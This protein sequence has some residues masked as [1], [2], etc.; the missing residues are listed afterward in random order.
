MDIAMA[1]VVIVLLIVSVSSHFGP[2]VTR[3]DLFFG[4]TV[5]PE[6]RRTDAARRILHGYRTALWLWTVLVIAVAFAF[7]RFV[8]TVALYLAGLFGTLIGAHRAASRH[9][10]VPARVIEVDLAAPPERIPGGPMAALLPFVLLSGLGAWA[11][12][13]WNRL[14][15]RLT[16]HWGMAGP[17]GRVSTSA[18]AVLA[19][20]A[21]P[22]LF[23]LLLT[24]IAFGVLHWSRRIESAGAGAVRERE[25]RRRIVLLI[26]LTEYFLVFPP[27]FALL[28][29][30]WPAVQMWTVAVLLVMA[31]FVATLMR[32][33]QGG[34]GGATA[35]RAPSIG[36]RTPD[37]CWK[38]GLFYFNRQDAALFIEKRMGVGYT[39]NFGNVWAWVLL[40]LFLAVPMVL[41]LIV[42]R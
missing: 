13:H 40:A 6:F 14:P 17:D 22:A 21:V 11:V 15:E 38:W 7:D 28:Q 35:T 4:V 33:G 31:V 32:A 19:L 27:A 24:V 41:R 29:P 1:P 18:Q 12:F 2:W 37:A 20:L 3:P 25:F 34:S 26:L 36:D 30:P 16:V 39:L 8:L 42:P 23:C 9:A 10:I 5:A